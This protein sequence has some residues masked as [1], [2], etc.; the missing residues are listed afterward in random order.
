MAQSVYHLFKSTVSKYPDRVAAQFKEG[1]S[2]KDVTWGEMNGLA[3]SISGALAKHGFEAKDRIAIQ[4]NTRFEWVVADLGILGA[5]GT[6][7]PIYQSNKAEDCAYILNDSGAVAVFAEDAAQLAKLRE[8]R[9]EIPNV[10]LI[11]CFDDAAVD[12]SDD[13]EVGWD[14]FVAEG[15]AH[16]EANADA[17]SAFADSLTKDDLLTLIYTSGTTGRPKGVMITQDNMI[18]EAEAI[19]QLE[20]IKTEDVQLM[21]MPLAHVFAKVLEVHWF[22]SAH[23]MAFAESIDKLVDN[24][25]EVRPTFMASVPRIFEKVHAKVVGGALS[26]TGLKGAIAK[27]GM[28]QMNIAIKT[29]AAGGQPGGLMWAL[30]N[31]LVISKIKQRLNDTFG[32]RLKFLV[33]GGAP[34]SKD[35][36][37]FFHFADVTICEGY[38]LT[39]TSAATFV[40]L[41]GDVRIGT[42]GPAFPG[43]EVQIAAD[44]EILLR[45]RGVFAGYWNR[46]DATKEA[47]GE[48]GWF[49]TGDIGQLDADGYL[50]ITDRKKDI[51]VTA[52]GKNVAPQNIENLIKTKSP[53]ISQVVVHGDKR[54]FL[55]AIVTLDEP[56][57]VEWAKTKAIAGDFKTVT[58]SPAVRA[59]IESAMNTANGE[60][61]RF[62][63]IKKFE[64]LDH[65]FE[66]GVQL[67]P[68]LKVK[69][70]VCNERYAP[71]FDGF[72]S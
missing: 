63:T 21:W 6:T 26:A 56:T 55:S 1:G 23:V 43:T 25:S 54:K 24:M 59:E 18:Y 9:A 28:D 38:G 57:T 67:T 69:R 11:V 42:V 2:W 33:S 35:I 62:E 53:L 66:V 44:G 48:G 46:D 13:L 15:K 8:V 34:L 68:S 47:F 64:V 72:Y 58:K 45:G 4:S 40:N 16:Y 12:A 19:D 70:K 37:W 36:A 29:A 3:T 39:E 31:K 50:R 10:R 20:L 41:P 49:H 61:A 71:I 65:D 7:V 27:F 51:I 30:A 17:I 32:G 52:G 60:L 22:H 5:G 14:A